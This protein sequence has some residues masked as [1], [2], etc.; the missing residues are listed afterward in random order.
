MKKTSP[1][2]VWIIFR[3][4]P[5]RFV[6]ASSLIVSHQT[7]CTST[8]TTAWKF[9][10]K[11]SSTD[12]SPRFFHHSDKRQNWFNGRK[13]LIRIHKV[14]YTIIDLHRV[15]SFIKSHKCVFFIS[16]TWP[17]RTTEWD[18]NVT[19]GVHR[20][21]KPNKYKWVHTFKSFHGSVSQMRVEEAIKF[22][23]HAT[24]LLEFM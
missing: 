16:S 22:C 8:P 15:E 12:T 17:Y 21:N 5:D 18:V 14:S 20:M 24:G 10:T 7:H 3:W 19:A 9:K 4:C 6:V 23:N 1:L 13:Q 2:Q 11:Y